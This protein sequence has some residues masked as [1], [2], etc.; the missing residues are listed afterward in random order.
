MEIYKLNQNF[1]LS[2]N[3][4]NFRLFSS[5]I[6]EIRVWSNYFFNTEYEQ[7]KEFNLITK[8]PNQ[9]IFA[10]FNKCFTFKLLNRFLM[11][12]RFSLIFRILMELF[13]K[14]I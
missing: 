14:L 7:T 10:I 4:N 8:I 3:D 6:N 1:S 12:K 11:S 5:L 9:V 13:T 2:S